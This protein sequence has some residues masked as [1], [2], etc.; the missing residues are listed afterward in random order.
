MSKNNKSI[1]QINKLNKIKSRKRIRL[2][3]TR[4]YNK[5]NGGTHLTKIKPQKY[6][7]KSGKF[8]IAASEQGIIALRNSRTMLSE[9]YD[10]ERLIDS[11]QEENTL[12]IVINKKIENKIENLKRILRIIENSASVL[13]SYEN[14]TL[15]T[16]IREFLLKKKE[17]KLIGG[18][19]EIKRIFNIDSNSKVLPSSDNEYEDSTISLT[20][21]DKTTNPDTS[22]IIDENRLFHHYDNND[23]ARQ[24][25]RYKFFLPELS[26]YEFVAREG[27]RYY[28]YASNLLEI[29]EKKYYENLATYNDNILEI[30][31]IKKQL[32]R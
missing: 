16:N 22:D 19:A 24:D 28:T 1:K 10:T 31:K 15:S 13:V 30:E 11:L 14:P 27:Y 29:Y 17:Q 26:R 9:T 32:E 12:L 6:F 23:F 8:D 4:K 2:N 25:S 21:S 5:K 20:G 3:K 7:D 18:F